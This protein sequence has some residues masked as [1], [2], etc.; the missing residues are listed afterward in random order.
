[1]AVTIVTGVN[2]CMNFVLIP[3]MGAF[4]AAIA[5]VA[6]ETVGA[7]IQ[8]LY[9]IFTKQLETK[10]IFNPCWKYLFSGM[11]M[12]FA[13]ERLKEIFSTGVV[14]LCILVGTGIVTYFVALLLLRDRFFI[15]NMAKLIEK[16]LKRENGKM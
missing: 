13:V 14:S 1:M 15:E 5:S 16:F 7:A 6:S 11:I 10:H 4:G 9:C 8:L 3:R 2:F 12:F